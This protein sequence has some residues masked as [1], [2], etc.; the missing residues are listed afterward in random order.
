MKSEQARYTSV[1]I[2]LHWLIALGILSLVLMGVVMVQFSLPLAVSYELYQL[3]KSIGVSVL[4]LVVLRT[5]WR[6]SHGA[7]PLPASMAARQETAA[8]VMHRLLYALMLWI[9]LTGW[10]LLSVSDENH[11]FRFFGTFWWP[12]VPLFGLLHR[13]PSTGNV[14]RIFHVYGGWIISAAVALHIVAALRHQFV[15]KDDILGRMLPDRKRELG[16]PAQS[17]LRDPALCSSR[18]HHIPAQE[19]VSE[20][21]H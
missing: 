3:H 21:K 5:L 6:L 17:S 9:P 16:T 8:N 14:V 11:P 12:E 4:L 10:F 1:A 7:P 13:N 19:D 18:P 20:A 15:H 2:G